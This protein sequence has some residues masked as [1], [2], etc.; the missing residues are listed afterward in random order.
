M[1][2]FYAYLAILLAFCW[3]EIKGVVRKGIKSTLWLMEKKKKERKCNMNKQNES[4]TGKSKIC[5]IYVFLKLPCFPNFDFLLPCNGLLFFHR[6]TLS[7][8][9]FG[10]FLIGVVAS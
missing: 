1:D 7:R 5:Y 9:I 4:I 6:E 10:S 8:R 2:D 3:F